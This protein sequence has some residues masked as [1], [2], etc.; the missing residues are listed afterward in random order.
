MN[1][2][3]TDGDNRF[4]GHVL[5]PN[6]AGGKK[7]DKKSKRSTATCHVSQERHVIKTCTQIKL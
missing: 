7:K 4:T 3:A 6:E 1:R 5:P 2:R